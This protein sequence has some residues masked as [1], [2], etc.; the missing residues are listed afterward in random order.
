MAW[1]KRHEER[2]HAVRVICHPTE[3]TGQVGMRPCRQTRG[4]L[5]LGQAVAGHGPFED[6]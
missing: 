4:Y 1:H 3:G 6:L 5:A 2:F